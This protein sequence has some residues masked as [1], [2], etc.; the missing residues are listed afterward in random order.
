MMNVYF[1]APHIAVSAFRNNS[2]VYCNKEL[3]RVVCSCVAP[4]CLPD[5]TL[6]ARVESMWGCWNPFRGNLC[7]NRRAMCSL[8]ASLSVVIAERYSQGANARHSISYLQPRCLCGKLV[9]KW[10]RAPVGMILKHQWIILCSEAVAAGVSVCR[11]L[12]EPRS[13]PKEVEGEGANLLLSNLVWSHG[14]LPH[15]EPQLQQQLRREDLKAG[16]CGRCERSTLKYRHH[17][18]PTQSF[19]I[20]PS[21]EILLT[22]T[23][24]HDESNLPGNQAEKNPH[25]WSRWCWCLSP[26]DSIEALLLHLLLPRGHSRA[27]RKKGWA[28]SEAEDR[29]LWDAHPRAP[30]GWKV[31]VATPVLCVWASIAIKTDPGEVCVKV[32]PSIPLSFSPLPPSSFSSLEETLVSAKILPRKSKQHEITIKCCDLLGWRSGAAQLRKESSIDSPVRN[33]QSSILSGLQIRAQ[34]QGGWRARDF[35]PEPQGP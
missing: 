12:C 4:F 31:C 10:E 22:Q 29:Q 3:S 7:T 16:K 11:G 32:L 25:V 14:C 1:Y 9:I 30:P 28:G 2:V 27:V 17:I 23:F 6:R 24:E 20:L 34:G 26:T 15:G 19:Q 35:F 13:L 18:P 5:L 8:Q 21:A 33:K